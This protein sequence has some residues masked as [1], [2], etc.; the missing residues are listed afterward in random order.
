MAKRGKNKE[1]KN[2]IERFIR[3]LYKGL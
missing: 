2:V 1:K 3:S